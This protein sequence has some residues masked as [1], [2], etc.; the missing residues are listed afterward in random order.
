[1]SKTSKTSKKLKTTAG[2]VVSKVWRGLSPS[3]PRYTKK[4][5]K[6]S[7]TVQHEKNNCDLNFLLKKYGASSLVQPSRES[8][9]ADLVKAPADLM[10]AHLAIDRA[11]AAFNSLPA[12]IRAEFDNDY[13]LLARELQNPEFH[14]EF[15]EDL[16]GDGDQ[17][18][19]EPSKEGVAEGEQPSPAKPTEP[20]A[21][22]DR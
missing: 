5:L 16:F 1:M 18:A 20:E 19:R 6:P 4:F 8:V 13:R 12:D 10:S 7:L 9:Y 22:A 3:R 11:K 2:Q 15:M 17:P 14:A 21:P